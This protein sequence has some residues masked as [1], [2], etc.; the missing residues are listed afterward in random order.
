MKTN[1]H[2]LS[3][4]SKLSPDQI[5]TIIHWLD[6]DNM[7]YAEGSARIAKQ[8]GLKTNPS[9]L[10]AFFQAQSKLRLSS[11]PAPQSAPDRSAALTVTIILDL[12]KPGI[13]S[14]QVIPGAGVKLEGGTA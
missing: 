7:T 3:P 9:S 12:S 5:A 14:L 13:V 10:C 4:L 8:F 11:P 2:N 6:H 1:R